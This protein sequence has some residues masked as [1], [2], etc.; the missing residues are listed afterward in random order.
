MARRRGRG[1][2]G[3][4][5]PSAPEVEASPR[6]TDEYR[7]LDRQ[8]ELDA[9]I[10]R[11]RPHDPVALDTEADNLHHYDTRVCLLQVR[12]GGETVLIDPLAGIS[13]AGL[14]EVLAGKSLIMHGSDFDLRLLKELAD[15]RPVRLF[16][17]MLAAQYLGLERIGLAALLEANFG[18][19]I[20]KDSQKSD[21]SRRPLT[22]KMLHYAATDVLYL[23]ELKKRLSARLE[24]LGRLRWVEEKCRWQ[25]EVAQ[26]GFPRP[27]ENAWRVGASDTLG[28]RGQAVL[29]ETWHWREAQARRMD[30][31]PFKVIGND[32]LVR[33]ARAAQEGRL[34]EEAEGLPR[35]LKK[36]YENGMREVLLRGMERDPASLPKRPP[37]GPSR[38]LSTQELKLHEVLKKHRNR[39]AQRL[40]IDPT[41]LASRTQLAQIA[42]HPAELEAVLLPWQVELFL[43]C[44]ALEAE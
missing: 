7:F 6:V 42:R 44:P 40:G 18:V 25:I 35:G 24:T 11:L 15:F 33:L 14:F 21:W 4:G 37:R 10:E 20:P 38:P 28:P 43:T 16:D 29:Y 22:A 13:L 34:E 3:G 36:R 8:E 23:E 9:F 5:G 1:S 32:Y 2:R 27:S 12:A 30:R 19:A 17:T 31:P 26:S 41:L 39:E